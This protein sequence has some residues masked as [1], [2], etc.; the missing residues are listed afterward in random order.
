MAAAPMPEA[1]QLPGIPSSW[2][3]SLGVTNHAVLLN[4]TAAT[5]GLS[6][7]DEG[8]RK[9]P[10]AAGDSW[11]VKSALTPQAVVTFIVAGPASGSSTGT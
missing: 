7:F 5:G 11:T 9:T 3:K 6:G 4:S 1:W 10:G 8:M 2:A